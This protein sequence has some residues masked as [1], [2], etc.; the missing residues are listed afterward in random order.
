LIQFS[1]SFTAHLLLT[2]QIPE[3]DLG[4]GILPSPAL[5]GT[6]FFQQSTL[7][8]VWDLLTFK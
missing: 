7:A 3:A 5:A 6:T 1:L 8:Q 2:Y 4:P